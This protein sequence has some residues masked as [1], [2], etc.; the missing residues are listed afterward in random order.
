MNIF[1][2]S[3]TAGENMNNNQALILWILFLS[4]IIIPVAV[5]VNFN[6]GDSQFKIVLDYL[7]NN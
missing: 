6:M 3:T 2:G 1:N 4:C 5:I 7:A